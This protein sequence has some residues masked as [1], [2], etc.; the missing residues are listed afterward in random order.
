MDAVRVA[1]KAPKHSS[2]ERTPTLR[3]DD[4]MKMVVQYVRSGLNSGSFLLAD[5]RSAKEPLINESYAPS[6]HS[7]ECQNP[8]KTIAYWMLVLLQTTLGLHPAGALRATRFVPDESVTSMTEKILIQSFLKS[9][10][11]G[12][13]YCFTV[14]AQIG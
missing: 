13:M 10:P 12:D 5:A 11:N 1:E 9:V 4:K 2:L 6:R 3:R 8:V 14:P 7:G